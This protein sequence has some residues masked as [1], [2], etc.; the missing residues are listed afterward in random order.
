MRVDPR[1]LLAARHSG[2][3]WSEIAERH[4]MTVAEVKAAV[5]PLRVE[6]RVAASS[7]PAS[8]ERLAGKCFC[9]HRLLDH[10]RH[11]QHYASPCRICGPERTRHYWYD[12]TTF[13]RVESEVLP[14]LGRV[15]GPIY[16]E[17]IGCDEF[18]E[19]NEREPFAPRQSKRTFVARIAKR[20]AKAEEREERDREWRHRRAAARE[21][22][23]AARRGK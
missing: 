5:E 11:G 22:L 18:M 13:E 16:H 23:N 7:M 14:P 17:V 8:E 1:E 12:P 21:R 10:G 2:R 19:P 3:S 20:F 4:A 9:R 15:Y 6:R